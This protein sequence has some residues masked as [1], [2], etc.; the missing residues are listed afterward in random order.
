MRNRIQTLLKTSMSSHR[1]SS[2]RINIVKRWDIKANFL[3]SDCNN[4]YLQVM[5][6]ATMPPP[7]ERLAR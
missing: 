6:S 2:R 5:F 1:T 3:A 4:Y 7:V